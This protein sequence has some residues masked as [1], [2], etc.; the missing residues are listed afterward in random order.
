MTDDTENSE[1]P[2]C[3]IN[4]GPDDGT[5]NNGG[6]GG[7][8]GT[9]GPGGSGDNASGY[10]VSGTPK[11]AIQFIANL[12][13]TSQPSSLSIN[14]VSGFSAPVTLSVRSI[15]NA[16]GAS[17]PAGVIPTYYFGGVSSSSLLMTYNP[18]F[19]QYTNPSGTIGTT[20]S[21]KLSKK[22]TEKYYITLVGTSGAQ[23]ATF[24]IE[25]NPNVLNPDFREI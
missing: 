10:T 25:L 8:G 18:A 15:Q 9:N 2:P 6:N 14:P 17:L 20:F 16:S 13:A 19:G 22:I 24:I 23:R 3:T 7:A 12:P 1:N 4:C 11:V 21:V 5:G